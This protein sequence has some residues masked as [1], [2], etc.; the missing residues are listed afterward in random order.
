MPVQDDVGEGVSCLGG[1]VVHERRA[2]RERVVDAEDRRQLLVL[3]LHLVERL[4]CGVGVDRRHRDDRL[5]RVADLADGEDRAVTQD[6]PE[7]REDV[8]ALEEVRAGE[9]RED[10]AHLTCA[11]DVETGDPR[12]RHGAAQQLRDGHIRQF[13]VDRVRDPAGHAFARIDQPGE[14]RAGY[15]HFDSDATRSIARRTHTSMIALRYQE[16]PRM[17]SSASVAFAYPAAIVGTTSPRSV[18]LRPSASISG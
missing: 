10:A 3:D 18:V 1:L 7:I 5:A 17:S 4:L 15:A 6:R 14:R 9:D 13:D 11:R 8:G 12:V 2:R 16:E